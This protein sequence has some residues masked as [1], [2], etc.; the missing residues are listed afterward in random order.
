[1]TQQTVRR[2]LRQVR[3]ALA[4]AIAACLAVV[5]S[6]EPPVIGV[7]RA[8]AKRSRVLAGLY[9]FVQESLMARLRRR[10]ER[11]RAVQV[12][13]HRLQ[14]DIADQ[15]GR[16]PYFYGTPYEPGVTD[17]IAGSLEPGDVF[18][19]VGANIGYY[20]VLAAQ[21]VGPRGRVVAF[22]PHAGARRMLET[23]VRRNQAS[24]SVEIVPL[25][26]AD[27]AGEATL[28]IEEG[29]T[30]HSTIEPSLS[31]MRHVAAFEPSAVVHVTTLD[32]WLASH[33]E[34]RPRVRCLKIDVE[35]AEARVLAGMAETLQ[36]AALTIIC[37]T[38]I[39][40]AA[41]VALTRA[42]FERRRTESGTGSYGNFLYVR[43]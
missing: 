30:A 18:V 31:P 15:T 39:G 38:T 12:R 16:M 42:G 26:V 3:R 34:L 40:G 22:E 23:M 5:P 1:M 20:T 14:L 35:G 29:V 28:F 25:A 8:A 9:W 10:G 13:G 21:V 2:W 24:A 6:L 4:E 19:D 17:A 37:E 36:L 7:G 33:P 27:V 32:A 11:F 43:P 41:D